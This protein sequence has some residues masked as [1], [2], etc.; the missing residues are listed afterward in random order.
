MNI[1]SKK[2]EVLWASIDANNHM[3][4]SSYNDYAAQARIAYFHDHGFPINM[5]KR[6]DL[7]PILFK[8][9]TYFIRE[10][11]LNESI[12]VS[13]SCAALRKDG[14][15]WKIFHEIYKPELTLACRIYVDGAWLDLQKR[16]TI[17]PPKALKDML[18]NMPRTDDFS[19]IPDKKSN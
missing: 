7:G 17:V 10:V 18:I 1:Y 8:E 2:F 4:H 11:N 14:S 9:E 15:K 12:T 16:K 5:F 19:W 3:R 13:C 6:L